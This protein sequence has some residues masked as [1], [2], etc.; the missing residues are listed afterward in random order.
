MVDLKTIQVLREKT[1][2]GLM[3][4]KKALMESDG[5]VEK[6]VE[7]LRKRGM[8]LASKKSGNATSNGLVYAYIHAG[9]RIG[10]LV[11]ITC[12]TDFVARTDAI[13]SFARDIAMHIAAVNPKY[14]S[15][16]DVDEE[17]LEKEKEII[18]EQLKT[19]NKPQNIIDGIVKGKI[20]KFCDDNCLLNQPFVKNDKIAIE[21]YLKEV[22][23]K[24][25][26]NVRIDAFTRY[27]I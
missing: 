19:A 24:V 25:G 8:A 27:E 21:G 17:I 4:C 6:A 3:D 9:S 26:E 16:S 2:L 13:S 22:V 7:A 10:V 23:A 12:E 1:G 14:L 5:D 15:S 11:K 18:L 20:K